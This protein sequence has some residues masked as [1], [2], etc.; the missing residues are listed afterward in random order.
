MDIKAIP[1]FKL[2]LITKLSQVERTEWSLYASA[3]KQRGAAG[4]G[5]TSNYDIMPTDLPLIHDGKYFG[6]QVEELL[7]SIESSK[8]GKKAVTPMKQ[9]R[10]R[11][12]GWA[13][14]S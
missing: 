11:G 8:D 2:T 9:L 10:K 12:K 1:G 14:E 4:F 3:T 6:Q 13:V 7:I 5:G